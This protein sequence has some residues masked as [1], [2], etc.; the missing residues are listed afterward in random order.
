GLPPGLLA[1]HFL[2]MAAV[3][4]FPVVFAAA[5]LSPWEL[6]SRLQGERFVESAGL[7]TE[8]FNAAM[9]GNGYGRRVLI[10]LLLISL[11]VIV[12]LQAVFYLSAAGLLGLQRITR[13]RLSFRERISLFIMGSTL[14]AAF[15]LII[16][17]WLPAVH[18]IVFYLAAILLVFK[19]SDRI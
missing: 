17:I 11:G 10:P 6:F 13:S 14:P 15:S 8:E 7:R 5:R 2:M 18:L 16:G 1:L 9:Y 19:G 12:I 3:L 4:H